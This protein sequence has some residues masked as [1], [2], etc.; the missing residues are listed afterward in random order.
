MPPGV[1]VCVAGGLVK[2]V[3][4][5]MVHA[6]FEYMTGE[7]PRGARHGMLLVQRH[8][9]A[10]LATGGQQGGGQQGGG[11]QGDQGK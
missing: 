9:P 5:A 7:Y 6:Y 11:Q 8:G 1:G 2:L 10:A 4:P 3:S